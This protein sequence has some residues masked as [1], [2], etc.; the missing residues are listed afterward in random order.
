LL[1]LVSLD[2]CGTPGGGHAV[3]DAATIDAAVRGLMA[4]EHVQ[5]LALAVIDAGAIRYVAAYG[6]RNAERALPLTTKTIMYGASLTK[7]AFAYMTL[8]LVDEGRLNL[9]ASIADLLP[10][11]P[12]EYDDYA[13]LAG[14]D[15]WR[16]LFRGRLLHPPTDPRGKPRPGR[17]ERNAD[18]SIRPFRHDP[19]EHAMT[20]GLGHGPGRR[21]SP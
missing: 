12:P 1:L 2:G 8:Q 3:P 5:G 17:W 10:R 21:L 15:R 11:P 4:R 6:V 16:A 20:A 7:T 13:D 14:D 18:P 9:D 19:H